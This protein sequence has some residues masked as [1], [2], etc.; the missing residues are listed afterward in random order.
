MSR[1]L[2]V[3]PEAERDLA[4]VKAWYD[5]QRDGLGDEYAPKLNPVAVPARRFTS[6]ALTIVSPSPPVARTT[7]GVPYFR[8]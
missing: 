5:G 8:L 4:E 3:N 6:L 2:I 7:G 1:P